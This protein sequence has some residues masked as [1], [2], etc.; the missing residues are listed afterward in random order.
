MAVTAALGGSGQAL[1]IEPGQAAT[2]DLTLRTDAAAAETVRLKVGGPA[3]PFS[4]CVPDTVT[5]EPGTG[6]VARVGF[7]LPRTSLPAAGPLPFTVHAGDLSKPLAQGVVEVQPFSALSVTLDPTEATAKGE[8]RHRVSV[9][10]RGN[11]PV[12]VAI[13]AP[14]AEG[15]DV[16]VEPA[17]VVV[18]P[19]RPATADV[20]VTPRKRLFTGAERE[21]PFTVVATPEI[22]A[23]CELRGRLCQQVAVATRT[24]VRSGVVAGVAVIALVVALTALSGGSSDREPASEAAG[25]DTG[26]SPA[27][28]DCP[29]KDHKDPGG[30]SGLRP[31]DI[32]K[33]PNTYSFLFVDRDGCTPIRFNPCEPIHYVQNLALAPPTGPADVREAFAKLGEAT[34][35]TF[36]DDG[37]TD[38]TVRRG[39]PYLPNRYGNRWAPI[40]VSWIPFGNQGSDPTIQQVGRGI[41]APVG[42][43]LVSGQLSLNVDAVTNKETRTPVQGGF[44]PPI[45]S[46]VGAIGPENVTWGRIILHELAH[47]IGLGHTRDKGAIMYPETAD[48]TSRPSEYRPP[49]RDGLRYL[50]RAAGCLNTPPLPT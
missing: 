13:T 36:V 33:L 43:V 1:A 42:N 49:D 28:D 23:P 4:F 45:G 25:V 46:G 11:A 30:V 9:G 37:T 7:R 19:D 10:N 6:A 22:G 3:S 50:G 12:S 8:S 38:E 34:G 29:A 20:T 47:V 17:T 15:I 27:T 18:A 35:I 41:G 2:L 24:L 14:D 40:L 21:W 48:Q 32:P 26:P 44:G 5:V 39:T 31:D 16:A